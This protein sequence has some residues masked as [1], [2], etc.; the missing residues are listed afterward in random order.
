MNAA[1]RAMAELLKR[2]RRFKLEAY[3]FVREALNYA[4]QHMTGDTW[5]D[6]PDSEDSRHLTGQ[7]L[8]EA[9]RRFA[10][11]QYGYLSKLVLASWGL[12]STSD[13]GDVVYNLIEIEHMRK[14]P[15]DRRE[16]FDGV[17][18][19][20]DAFEPKFELLSPEEA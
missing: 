8:C 18:A 5:D 6:D 20:E 1:Q 9:C 16:D 11:E 10:L 17:Y 2:D 15:T 14:S 4:H 3:V 12:R 7:Q 13:F 19:F